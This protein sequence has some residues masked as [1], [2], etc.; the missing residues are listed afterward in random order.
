MCNIHI[1]F[2]RNSDIIRLSNKTSEPIGKG[3]KKMKEAKIIVAKY[4]KGIMSKEQVL[5]YIS[6]KYG[7]MDSSVVAY[8]KERL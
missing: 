1:A 3:D 5:E 8:I 6:V 2:K 4:Q 7:N